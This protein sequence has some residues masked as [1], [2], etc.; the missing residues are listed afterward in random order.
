MNLGI[1]V[2]LSSFL[3]A[4]CGGT[5]AR[6]ES[7]SADGGTTDRHAALVNRD[8]Q[9]WCEKE[10]QCGSPVSVSECAAQRLAHSLRCTPADDEIA[11]CLDRV[12]RTDCQTLGMSQ[13]ASCL[14][15]AK[16]VDGC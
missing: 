16:S 5:V 7:V 2:T 10:V 8:A 15:I 9:V 6:E 1:A 13:A 14:L 3:V 11:A 4:A 12:E